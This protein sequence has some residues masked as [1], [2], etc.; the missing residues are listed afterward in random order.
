M[1]GFTIIELLVVIAISALLSGLAITYSSIGRNEVSLTIAESELSQFILQA[2]ELSIATYAS[3]AIACGYGVVVNQASD[4]FSIFAYIPSSSPPCASSINVTSLDPTAEVPYTPATWQ[5][6]AT[7]G[8]L[9]QPPGST[10]AILFYPPDPA[11]FLSP[12]GQSVG[13]PSLNIGLMT[14]DGKNS[15]DLNINPEGQVNFY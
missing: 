8:V 3:N 6:H 5:V 15:A 9:L 7:Q 2:K 10:T 11:V 12:D 4:T 13:A 14:V 1:K